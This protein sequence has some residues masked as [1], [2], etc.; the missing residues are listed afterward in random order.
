M[1]R[2]AL[3][4]SV[5]FVSRRRALAEGTFP[6]FQHASHDSRGFDW[7]RFAIGFPFAPLRQKVSIFGHNGKFWE[8]SASGLFRRAPPT[9][10]R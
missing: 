10:P 8:V 7:L 9:L 3:A 4:G 6:R 1:S 2:S 5:G